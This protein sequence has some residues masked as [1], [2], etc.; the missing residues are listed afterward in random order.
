MGQEQS[1]IPSY[2]GL[3][4]GVYRIVSVPADTA[5]T[6]PSRGV[7]RIEAWQRS[8][9]EGQKWLVK[10]SG[11]GYTFQN[12]KHSTYMSVG[13]TDVQSQVYA[14]KFPTKWEL[15]KQGD[16]YLINKPGND[17]VLDLHWGWFTNGN[18]IH[19][20][21]RDNHACKHWKFEFLKDDTKPDTFYILRNLFSL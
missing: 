3:Q 21:P 10:P 15:L 5:I 2:H 14:S 8:N 16:H 9:D 17:R 1:N 6:I 11:D 18:K 4:P 20:R 7:E 19:I 13:S 12:R